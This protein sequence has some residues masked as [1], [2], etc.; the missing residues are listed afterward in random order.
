M[1]MP[2]NKG[3]ITSRVRYDFLK[4]MYVVSLSN[5]KVVDAAGKMTPI[6]NEADVNHKKFSTI[7]KV[8]FLLLIKRKS[9]IK[10]R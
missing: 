1:I 8:W 4:D 10:L 5:T 9:T 7:L 6:N 2:F 3:K